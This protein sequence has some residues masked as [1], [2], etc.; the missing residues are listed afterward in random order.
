VDSLS[1]FLN[2]KFNLDCTIQ[3]ISVKNQYSIYIN[4]K[5]MPILRELVKPYMPNS[6]YY[7]LGY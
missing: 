4:K 1:Q 6:M 7:K 3:N 2:N 5:S